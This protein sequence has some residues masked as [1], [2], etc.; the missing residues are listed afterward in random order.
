VRDYVEGKLL[1]NHPPPSVA[2]SRDL[3]EHCPHTL[4]IPVMRHGR[5]RSAFTRGDGSWSRVAA[6]AFLLAVMFGLKTLQKPHTFDT[7]FPFIHFDTTTSSTSSPSTPSTLS[8]TSSIADH[9][10]LG[11]G[12]PTP[13]LSLSSLLPSASRSSYNLSF[14]ERRA[15]KKVKNANSRARGAAAAELVEYYKEV[16]SDY[17]T[18]E[19]TWPLITTSNGISVYMSTGAT[20]AAVSVIRVELDINAP[21]EYAAHQL[22]VEHWSDTQAM[23]DP[24]F[25][26][27]E[28]LHDLGVVGKGNG[29]VAVKMGRRLTK[30]L[31][32]FG[33]RDLV[34]GCFEE[35][36]IA[37]EGR[38]L[39]LGFLS[40]S[41]PYYPPAVG[42]EKKKSK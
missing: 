2:P 28:L 39:R 13:T 8:P 15:A 12:W 29:Q 36:G 18:P 22:Q 27:W 10:L 16:S 1:F 42:K 20:N 32:T 21:L 19:T 37:K 30:R 40:V 25:D 6:Y 24:F 35:K 11:W 23:Q 17:A 34:L 14:R 33:R 3:L 9:T 4:S 26:K 7:A 41:H 38:W 5:G 31:L